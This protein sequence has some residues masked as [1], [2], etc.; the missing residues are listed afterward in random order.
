MNGDIGL[1]WEKLGVPEFLLPA[2]FPYL[3]VPKGLVMKVEG[4]VPYEAYSLR[5]STVEG[6]GTVWGEDKNEA[7][8]AAE[9]LALMKGPFDAVGVMRE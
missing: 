3:P 7:M 8:E 2:P 9:N 1:T 4:L 6:L 5:G